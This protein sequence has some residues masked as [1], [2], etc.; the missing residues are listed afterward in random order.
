MV[1]MLFKNTFICV[2]PKKK[3]ESEQ[4][5]IE[6]FI[7]LIMWSVCGTFL[8]FKYFTVDVVHVLIYVES[9]I[10]IIIVVF[11]KVGW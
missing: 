4:M 11:A 1:S 2:Q 9:C 10:L 6:I 7:I 5:M 3:L 8:L